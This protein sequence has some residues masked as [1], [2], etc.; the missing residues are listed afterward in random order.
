[1][2]P[3]IMGFGLGVASMAG[4][5]LVVWFLAVVVRALNNIQQTVELLHDLGKAQV[6][7]AEMVAE[8]TREM[9]ETSSYQR[10]AL[11]ELMDGEIVEL[12]GEDIDG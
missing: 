9:R 2:S 5:V 12:G 7:L 11:E 3:V 10:R 1:M 6:A 4:V 8:T